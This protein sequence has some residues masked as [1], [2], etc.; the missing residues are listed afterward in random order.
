MI[1][2]DIMVEMVVIMATISTV[3]MIDANMMRGTHVG[4]T[5]AIVTITI[6][7]GSALLHHSNNI[8]I[9]ENQF[10]HHLMLEILCLGLSAE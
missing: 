3:G 5:E 10:P 7:T 6:T 9:N 1:K 2:I 4:K 8:I